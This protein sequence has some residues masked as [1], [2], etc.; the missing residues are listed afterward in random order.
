LQGKARD[1]LPALAQRQK[2]SAVAANRLYEPHLAQRDQAIFE[3]LTQY[4]VEARFFDAN[5]LFRPGAL[6]NQQG[7]PYRVFTPF[8]RQARRMLQ[9]SSPEIAPPLPS[10]RLPGDASLALGLSSVESLD[11]LDAPC[12]HEKLHRHWRPGEDAAWRQFEHF[13]ETVLQNYAAD[14]DFPAKAG[15]SRLSAHLHFGEISPRQVFQGLTPMLLQADSRAAASVDCFLSELGWRE[16]AYHV[17]WHFPQ[18]S[19][20]SLNPRFNEA[21]WLEDASS[22]AAWQSARSGIALVDAGMR[23]LWET[24]WMHNRV[25][26]LVGS[27]LCKNLGIHWLSGARWF[28][29][30]LVDADLASNTLGWQWIAGCGVDAAPYYRIFNPDTQ[31]KKF[32][33]QGEYIR[34]WLGGRPAVQAIVDLGESRKRALERFKGLSSIA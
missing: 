14:R 19:Q 31:A 27:L 7:L 5:L 11:L 28:W 20:Q 4:G 32:D 18:S 25:R 17:L 1:V 22:L 26:M 9:V 2:A 12:W 24:G 30:T 10:G 34:R 3:S 8:W 6:L 15:S 13:I 23:E 33:P 21:F 29:D 16:F